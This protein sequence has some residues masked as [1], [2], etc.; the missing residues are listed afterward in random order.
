M[1]AVVAFRLAYLILFGIAA[2]GALILLVLH[3]RYGD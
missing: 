1:D 3:L 2:L